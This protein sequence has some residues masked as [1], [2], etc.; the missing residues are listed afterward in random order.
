MRSVLKNRIRYS[1][2]FAIA[3]LFF[4]GITIGLVSCSL[5]N[6]PLEPA[7][8]PPP[9]AQPKLTR[10]ISLV[11]EDGD[12][13]LLPAGKDLPAIASYRLLY[14]KSV[15]DAGTVTVYQYEGTM[16]ETIAQVD[17]PVPP[18][19]D[20]TMVI[21]VNVDSEKRLRLKTSV[22][23]TAVVKEFGPFPVE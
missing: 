16:H 14:E 5:R 23:E 3:L 1:L 19:K 8:P 10:S 9:P 17:V 13:E 15:E 2:R 6:N 7:S 12:V 11:A 22:M 20:S 18:M 4:L 21:T